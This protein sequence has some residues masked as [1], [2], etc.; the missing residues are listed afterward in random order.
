MLAGALTYP[1]LGD[2]GTATWI[3]WLAQG[4]LEHTLLTAFGVTNA[5]LA[6]LPVL[7]ALASAVVFAVLATPSVR[8][9][10]V[11]PAMYA[12]LAWS[13]VAI[14]GPTIAGDPI[15]PLGDGSAALVLVGAGLAASVGTLLA[16]R[17]RELRADRPPRPLR[18]EPGFEQ[19]T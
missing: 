8:L 10:G 16:L 15:A 14:V 5:W 12:L 18:A 9:G 19:G 7:A 1:L 17:H 2:T 6:I 13:L 11:A 3:S 4:S